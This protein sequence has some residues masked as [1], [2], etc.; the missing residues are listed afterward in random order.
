MYK[1]TQPSPRDRRSPDILSQLEKQYGRHHFLRQTWQEVVTLF[2]LSSWRSSLTLKHW[3]KRSLD[4]A[5]A[6]FF[7]MLLTPLFL[8]TALAI[9]IEDG[10][11]I[12]YN[13]TRVT[14]GGKLF[15]MF[16]F[17]SMFNNA[18]EIK[19]TLQSDETTGS[20]IFK[21]KNDPRITR[22]G[23]IIRK[24]SIDELPQLWNVLIG[25]LSLVGP[26]PPLPDEVAEYTPKDVKRLSVTPGLTC[27]W[28]VSG[29][30]D[31]DFENQVLMDIDYIKKRSPLTDI[32]LL[33][34]TIPAVLSGKG[35]Y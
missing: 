29:R 21:M 31:I 27:I 30:S 10:R 19:K 28:Q 8:V 26:R 33:L 24:L 4:F 23:K 22:S 1:N 14:R 11:P 34:K 16:K 35:A 17:R 5:G 25:E 15:K 32:K 9:L 2:H 20:V 12:F 7:L 13:Q 3:F 6:L 18:D